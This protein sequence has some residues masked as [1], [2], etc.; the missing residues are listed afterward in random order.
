MCSCE[1]DCPYAAGLSLGSAALVRTVDAVF[2]FFGRAKRSVAEKLHLPE[3][4]TK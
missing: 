4:T 1:N 2:L 3:T